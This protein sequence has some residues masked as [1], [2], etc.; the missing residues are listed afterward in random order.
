MSSFPT[1]L[2]FKRYS[3]PIVVSIVVV[4][5]TL[6]IPPVVLGEIPARTYG[7]VAALLIISISP[8]LPYAVI[9]SF[10]TLPLLYAGIASFAAPE[11][12][13]DAPHVFSAEA[14]IRHV[15]A[16]IS[17]VLSAAAV[18]AIG[19]GAQLEVRDGFAAI[20]T[21]FQ[22]FVLYF[23]GVLVA[24]VFVVFQ[25]WRYDTSLTKISWPTLAGTVALGILLALSPAVALWILSG[26]F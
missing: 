8:T 11:P 12:G 10:G 4:V 13:A 9:V 15:V 26:S 23:G 3:V 5:A 14:I 7:L 25:L 22:P 20:P 19:I 17:Y 1:T 2:S 16:G 24:G 6:A 18:G 21:V